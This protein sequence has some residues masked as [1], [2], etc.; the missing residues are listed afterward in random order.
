MHKPNR[1]TRPAFAPG[2]D[3]APRPRPAKKRAPRRPRNWGRMLKLVALA[4]FLA[5]AGAL[6]FA[7]PALRVTK[8]RV[9][10]ARTLTPERVFAEARVPNRTNIFWMLRQPLAQRLAQDPVVDHA[11]RRI[12]L[13]NLLIL[14][15]TERRPRA[16][17]AG[18]GRFWLLDPKGVPY[19]A[20]DRPEPGLPIV[21][22]APA[23][24][25]Q[26]VTLG[27]PLATAWVREAY[28]LLALVDGR[29]GLAG[30]KITV[31]KSLNL[32]LNRKDKLQIRLG[33]PDAL[34]L[35]VA[36]ADASVTAEGGALA[37]GAAY[38]D[39]SCPQQPVYRPRQDNPN[40]D[41]DDTATANGAPL[42]V[43]REAGR[44][45]DDGP[46]PRRGRPG[47]R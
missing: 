12:R 16:T 7:N 41:S 44:D 28:R 34:P 31:D 45:A 29:P 40:D 27:R 4:L 21:Q 1:R 38:I 6:L 2:R 32:C 39:V 37:R 19:R 11:S 9:D 8:V 46:Q 42:G 3:A 35:K 14:S 10:G 22:V 43:S 18:G 47:G 30:A 20:L 17:L 26:S 25:P 23:A 36:L 15:V 5:D 13:P 33:Q 24:L